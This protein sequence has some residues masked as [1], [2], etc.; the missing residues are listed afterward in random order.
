M[1]RKT[2][3]CN[4]ETKERFDD[5]KRDGETTD[6][7]LNRAMDALEADEADDQYPGAPRCT[8]CGNKAHVWTVEDGMLVCG[9]CADGDI[10]LE[11]DD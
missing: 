3:K 10:E 8:N 7:F 4:E 1:T 5:L 2:L 11:I 9:L 6:G